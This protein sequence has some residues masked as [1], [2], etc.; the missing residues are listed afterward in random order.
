MSGTNIALQSY[1][2]RLSRSLSTSAP[3]L[4]LRNISSWTLTLSACQ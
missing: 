4:D 3:P 1:S 2:P